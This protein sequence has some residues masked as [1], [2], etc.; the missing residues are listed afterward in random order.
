MLVL[1]LLEIYLPSFIKRRLFLELIRRT[2]TAFACDLPQIKGSYQDLLT[3]YAAFTSQ[4]AQAVTGSE[5]E[6]IRITL[7]HEA[8]QMGA[9]LR[10]VL[11][12]HTTADLARALRLIYS[13]LGIDLQVKQDGD[14]VV[15]SCLFS[16][17]YDDQDCKLFSALD[18]GLVDGLSGG[19][20]L[21]FTRRLT[22]NADCCRAKITYP[23]QH[24]EGGHARA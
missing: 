15:R 9:K 14:V 13:G 20:Q 1:S 4:L 24:A 5:R 12:I 11:A 18:E 10:R 3:F 19:A 22:E 7:Y 8:K 17:Y 6:A 16:R 2:A 23:R 21:R